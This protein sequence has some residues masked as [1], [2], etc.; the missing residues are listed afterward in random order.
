MIFSEGRE[1][2]PSARQRPV[3]KV[4][5]FSILEVKER[6]KNGEKNIL[7]VELLFFI[8]KPQI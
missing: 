8:H 6:P 5:N 3:N 7:I 4:I 2:Y 1:P